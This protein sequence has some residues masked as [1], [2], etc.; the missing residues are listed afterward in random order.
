[1]KFCWLSGW[2][3]AWV[4]EFHEKRPISAV[5]WLKFFF[6]GSLHL[7]QFQ[8][9]LDWAKACEWTSNMLCLLLSLFPG[10][11]RPGRTR[12][13]LRETGMTGHHSF[14]GKLNRQYQHILKK[15]LMTLLL[16]FSISLFGVGHLIQNLHWKETQQCLATFIWSLCFCI[17]KSR[18][19]KIIENYLHHEDHSGLLA[20]IVVS[21]S[22]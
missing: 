7:A 11:A 2:E 8:T 9:I 19:G 15:V 13:C 1:M 21:I 14:S 4:A 10:E 17:P 20:A 6:S 22:K 12:A 3:G 16:M 5:L 18:S